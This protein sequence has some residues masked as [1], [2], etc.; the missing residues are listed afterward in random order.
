MKPPT[1]N[2]TAYSKLLASRSSLES[3]YLRRKETEQKVLVQEN[4]SN[5]EEINEEVRHSFFSFLNAAE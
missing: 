3:D 4:Q 5:V 2:V 1:L